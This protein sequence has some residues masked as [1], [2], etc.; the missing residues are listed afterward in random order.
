MLESL[1]WNHN[2]DFQWSSVAA[3]IAFIGA[4][5]SAV[6]S[7][8]G[9]RNSIKT[10]ENQHRMEQKKIDADIISKSR[11]HWIDSTKNIA[12]EFLV[13]SLRVVTV[14]VMLV[15]YYYYVAVWKHLE[16]DN[17]LALKSDKTDPEEKETAI[18]F[19]KT[20]EKTLHDYKENVIQSNIQVNELMYNTSKN[21]ALLLLNFSDNTENNEIIS[22]V[23]GINNDLRGII[24]ESK[25]LEYV[26]DD[27]EVD[28][29]SAIKKSYTV[30]K[31]INQKVEDLTLVLRDYF[32]KEWEKVKEGK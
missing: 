22:F 14:N 25:D 3:A 7:W 28:W 21:N 13:D 6:F 20:I 4:V 32:K 31:D 15:E 11:M 1:F 18:E 9:Y 26:V 8:L 16:H 5:S 27:E 24:K 17:Y 2:R 29:D 23:K 10:A 30:K 12:S 19:E